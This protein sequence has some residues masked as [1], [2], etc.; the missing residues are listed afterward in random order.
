M[1]LQIKINIYFF[2]ISLIILLLSSII[3]YFVLKSLVIEEV[4]ET[5]EAEK[6]NIVLQL[7]N[8][9]N[10]ESILENHSYRLEI[11]PLK[12]GFKSRQVLSDTLL[13]VE[14]KDEREEIPFRQLKA[15]EEI[16]GNYYQIILRRSL[17]EQDDLIIGI[18]VLLVSTF[19]LI[20][21]ALNLINLFGEKKWWRP[22]KITL[23]KLLDFNLSQANKIDLPVSDIDEF[24]E[25]NKTL[26]SMTD[27][28]ISDYRNLKEFSENASHEMQTPLAIIRSKL[29]VMIQDKSLSEGQFDSIHSLYMAVNRLAK[30]NQS[31]NLLTKIEN[32]E[33]GKKEDIDLSLLLKEQLNNLNELIDLKL[34]RVKTEIKKEVIVQMNPFIAETLISNLV[35]NSVKHNIYS[36]K[37][38]VTL[39]SNELVIQNNGNS[40][41]VSTNELFKRFKKNSQ[42]SDSPG[43]GLSIVKKICEL[44]NFK[45]EYEFINGSHII[46]VKFTN[47]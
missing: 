20:I 19:L 33:Y 29:D 38:I 13:F 24:N 37:I 40:P 35:M 22:F 21:V 3:S 45:I 28:L 36:G 9:N 42:T 12:N 41:T 27:K 46:S 25:L 6:N 16:N 8:V 11:H 17:I 31:L 1:K 23:K 15:V 34:L 26:E 47:I 44:N 7:K 14:S 39:N 10:P 18:S 2:S 43:L 4:D 30:L 32:Q 5:L